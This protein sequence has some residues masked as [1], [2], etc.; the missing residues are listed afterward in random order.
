MTGATLWS[1][2]DDDF[3][4][5]LP[6]YLLLVVNVVVFFLQLCAPSYPGAHLALDDDAVD[7][8]DDDLLIMMWQNSGTRR[9]LFF[10]LKS[11]HKK[12]MVNFIAKH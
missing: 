10:F 9:P 4:C 2:C 12:K 7:V 6:K 8:I 3:F 5:V 11:A 1:F